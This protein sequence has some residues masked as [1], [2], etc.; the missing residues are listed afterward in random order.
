MKF[1]YTIIFGLMALPASAEWQQ[2]FDQNTFDA[3]VVDTSFQDSAGNWFRF[4]SDGSLSGGSGGK[5]L[6][7]TWRFDNGFA[8]FDRK[9]GKERLPSDCIVVLINGEQLVTVRN[10]GKGRQTQYTRQ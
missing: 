10:Q 6:T 2:I 3:Q 4:N 8:C 5:D 7:G 1:L 9:L